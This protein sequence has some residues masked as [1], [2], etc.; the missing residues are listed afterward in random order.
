V[1]IYRNKLDPSEAFSTFSFVIGISLHQPLRSTFWGLPPSGHIIHRHQNLHMYIYCQFSWEF[2]AAAEGQ[3]NF[4]KVNRGWVTTTYVLKCLGWH[5]AKILTRVSCGSNRDLNLTIKAQT[6]QS[7]P[8]NW[9]G[10]V[11]KMHLRNIKTF[12]RKNI[13]TAQ[14]FVNLLGMCIIPKSWLY[15]WSVK[16]VQKIGGLLNEPF[17]ISQ[18]S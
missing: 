13:E 9:F 5:S 8:N 14:I 3:P 17:E 2:F 18:P 11:S 12:F 6:W 16:N 1:Q 7:S 4:L 10:G 15:A